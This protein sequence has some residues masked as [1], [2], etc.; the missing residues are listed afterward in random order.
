MNPELMIL[1]LVIF[2]R[3]E[4]TSQNVFYMFVL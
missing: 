1:I 3:Q 2:L 4:Q